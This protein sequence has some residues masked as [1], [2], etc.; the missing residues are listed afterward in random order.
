M[1]TGDK[2]EESQFPLYIGTYRTENLDRLDHSL[3]NIL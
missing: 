3:Q 2:K 1:F